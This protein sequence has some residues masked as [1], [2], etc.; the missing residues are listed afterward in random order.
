MPIKS[1]RPTSAA[2]RHGTVLDL[3]EVTRSK[4]EEC[5]IEPRKKKGGRNNHGHI[6]TRRIGGGNKQMYR[7]IDFRRDKD[8]IP[9]KVAHIEYDPNRSALIALLH[10]ADGEK[11]YILA[12]VGITVGSTVISGME[13]E[14][15]MGNAMPLA[16]IPVG[17]EVH[18][19]EQF[20]GS[21]GK[22]ARSAGMAARLSAR[23]GDYAL[24]VMPSNELRKVHVNC[25]ATIGRI[26]NLDWQNVSLGKAGR[27]RHRGVRPH[28]RGTA[29]NPVAHPMGGGE[30][31]TAGGR[32]SVS[33]WA[34]LSKGGKT[35]RPN[36]PSDR[37]IL[38][39]RPAGPHYQQG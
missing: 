10:Y 36:H 17:L 29:Q 32:Q 33:K 15:N 13:V 23:E 3:S 16:K 20:P 38:R 5:L 14:P 35:R 34:V 24:L 8:G 7:R 28:V 19:V 21:G 11:R 31:R 1:Y 39:R 26:G 18:N 4:P 27:N 25:R 22:I 30:G 2:R 6:A 37:F 9:A 12:P